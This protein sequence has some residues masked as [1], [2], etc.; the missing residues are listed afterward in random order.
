MECSH[1]WDGGVCG[2]EFSS[3]AMKNHNEKHQ[4]IQY[5]ANVCSRSGS[6]MSFSNNFDSSFMDLQRP[7]D[8]TIGFQNTE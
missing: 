5:G 4:C 8:N 6:L 3:S 7:L 1:H 2:K